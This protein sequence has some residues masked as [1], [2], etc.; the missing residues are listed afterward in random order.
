MTHPCFITPEELL[1]HCTR[2]NYKDSGPGGQHR[3][4]VETGVQLTHIP[5]GTSAR[6][7]ERRQQSDNLRIALKRL[8]LQLA[9]EHRSEW[10]APS[11]LW[12]QRCQN[13]KI[14]CNLE[15]NDFAA[16][17]TELLNSLQASEYD[18]KKCAESLAISPSQIVKFLKKIPPALEGLNKT[19]QEYGLGM[20]R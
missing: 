8:R 1:K 9:L 14:V 13:K 4:K 15:H 12:S 10:Q 5:T 19:R 3:N 2:K 20:L 11:E 17:L 7:G 18:V 16:L 6:A